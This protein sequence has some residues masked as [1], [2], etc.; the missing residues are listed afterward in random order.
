MP[1]IKKEGG[2]MAESI[3]KKQLQDIT[4]EVTKAYNATSKLQKEIS[5]QTVRTSKVA[6]Q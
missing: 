2:K 1:K 3:D 4:T 6:E 5:I